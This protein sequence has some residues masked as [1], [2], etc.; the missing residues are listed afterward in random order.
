MPSPVAVP[1]LDVETRFRGML[2][3]MSRICP[4][5]SSNVKCAW[6]K[7]SR[8]F[9][10]DLRAYACIPRTHEVLRYGFV[11]VGLISHERPMAHSSVKA[12]AGSS[13]AARRAG[14]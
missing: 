11:A 14:T 1:P 13:F 7:P 9:P 10:H 5:L 6:P 8:P 12:A 3:G 2:T 4:G